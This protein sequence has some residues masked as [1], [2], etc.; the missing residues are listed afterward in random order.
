MKLTALQR[1]EKNDKLNDRK[2]KAGYTTDIEACKNC[3]SYRPPLRNTQGPSGFPFFFHPETL[4]NVEPQAIC[5][6]YVPKTG[7]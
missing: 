4:F 7:T 6:L 2:E 1:R 3:K 5:D